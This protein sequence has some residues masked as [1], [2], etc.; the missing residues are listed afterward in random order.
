MDQNGRVEAMKTAFD[1]WS[2][3]CDNLLQAKK[4]YGVAR[5][6]YKNTVFEMSVLRQEETEPPNRNF[7]NIEKLVKNKMNGKQK[8]NMNLKCFEQSLKK[9]KRLDVWNGNLGI[10]I[11]WLM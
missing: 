11:L 8:A 3:V 9:S 5:A 6:T 4:E 2:V 7:K 1:A 10:E